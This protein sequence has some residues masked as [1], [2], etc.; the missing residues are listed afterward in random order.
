MTYET[1]QLVESGNEEGL[2]EVAAPTQRARPWR[3]M[4]LALA[5]TSA[6]GAVM[7]TM[8]LPSNRPIHP[9]QRLHGGI[10]KAFSARSLAEAADMKARFDF[11]FAAEG[12]E[13]PDAMS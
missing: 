11:T 8:T 6:I 2:E 4:G 13:D 1:A 5:A 3:R 9:L 7:G 10:L 12:Q